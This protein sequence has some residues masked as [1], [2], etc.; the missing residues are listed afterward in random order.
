[1]VRLKTVIHVHTAYS[2]DS[3]RS[4]GD[5]VQT[6]VRQGVDCV[7]VTDHNEIRGALE[8]RDQGAVRVIIGEEIS[9]TDGHILGLF[10]EQRVPPGLSGR[11]TAERIKTQGGL[12]LAPHPGARLC[13]NSISLATVGR[14]RPWI[15]AIEVCNSQNPLF[16]EDARARRYCER[17]G[18]TPYVGAD[19]HLRGWLAGAYQWLPDFDGSKSFL[20]ALRQ[21]QLVR[22]RF[23]I[24]YMAAMAG[25]HYWHKLFRRPAVAD[26]ENA[27][28][29]A[30]QPADLVPRGVAG[31]SD[32][33]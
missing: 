29:A 16:W 30:T 9:S 20:S 33:T 28:G 14:L 6:A 17:H 7:A 2:Y 8:A 22:S 18:L 10:L 5:L 4:I 25:R 12:V 15:D 11:A 31:R 24:R 27:S 1:M 19:A 13:A 3:N 32:L 21:A 23:G 26:A